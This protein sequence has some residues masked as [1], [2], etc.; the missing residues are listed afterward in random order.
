MKKEKE[1]SNTNEEKFESQQKLERISS[2]NELGDYSII[3][4]E[5]SVSV[6]S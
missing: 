6:S 2:L 1:I 5:E 3:Y 4:E